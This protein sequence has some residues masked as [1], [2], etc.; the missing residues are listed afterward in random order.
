MII[1]ILE[2]YDDGTQALVPTEVPD[3]YLDV[4]DDAP[5]E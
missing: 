1:N 5:E 4:P 2:C 3:T